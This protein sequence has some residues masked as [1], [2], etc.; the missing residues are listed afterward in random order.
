[1]K[2]NATNFIVLTLT[3]AIVATLCLELLEQ[4]MGPVALFIG[5]VMIVGLYGFYLGVSQI[6]QASKSKQQ[7]LYYLHK[8]TKKPKS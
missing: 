5:A 1:M 8:T 7:R 4:L 3:I 2:K 6:I